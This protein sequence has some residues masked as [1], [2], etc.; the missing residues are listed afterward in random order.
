MF[1]RICFLFQIPH[2][3]SF[4]QAIDLLFKVH[5][6]FNNAFDSNLINFFMFLKYFVYEI[7]FGNSYSPSTKMKEIFNK[8]IR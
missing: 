3:Y 8:M 1:T 6:V 2:D 4:T 7:E 5:I